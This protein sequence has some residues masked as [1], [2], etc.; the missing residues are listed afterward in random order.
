MF[1]GLG[2]IDGN[3]LGVR[4]FD[5]NTSVD[6]NRVLQPSSLP[7]SYWLLRRSRAMYRKLNR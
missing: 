7:D 4:F 1:V 2:R 3:Y 6:L 5:K